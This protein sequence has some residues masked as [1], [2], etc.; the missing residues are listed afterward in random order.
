[1]CVQTG[2]LDVARVCLGHLK[3]ARSVRALRLAMEDDSLEDEAKTA[4]LAIELNMIEEAEN[5]Y[6]KC[7]RY[8]LLNKLLQACGRFEEAL[9]I[10]EQKDRVHLKHTYFKYA[11]WLRETG[12]SAEALKYYEKS[13]NPVHNVTQ[14]LMDDSNALRKYMQATTDPAMLKWFA[15]FLESTG[16]METAFKIYQKAEDW[17]SQVNY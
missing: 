11:E 4:I 12:E 17:F 8:D 5:L 2:R 9:Q 13:S 1:M 10:A 6:K 16:D 3:K 7:G 14:M 15:Q